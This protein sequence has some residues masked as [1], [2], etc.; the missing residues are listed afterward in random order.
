M[1]IFPTFDSFIHS[2]Y[3]DYYSLAKRFPVQAMSKVQGMDKSFP[4]PYLC[5]QLC[6]K[7]QD[8]SSWDLANLWC[9][10]FPTLIKFWIIISFLTLM[11]NCFYLSMG[12]KCRSVQ[13]ILMQIN[14][15]EF[16]QL[17]EL[18]F[19]FVFHLY[20]AHPFFAIICQ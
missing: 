17:M 14:I 12:C 16:S 2:T 8:A 18:K 3:F 6:Q 15:T 11:I 10:F 19:R 9:D 5:N 1:V 20:L 4:L 7:I 13:S